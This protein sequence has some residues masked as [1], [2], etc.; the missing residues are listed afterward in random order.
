[1]SIWT[2]LL[3]FHGHVATPRAL[4][5]LASPPAAAHAAP[6]AAPALPTVAPAPPAGPPPPLAVPPGPAIDPA[7]RDAPHALRTAHQLR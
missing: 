7:T 2:D 1:M 4:A 6:A 5:L 3:T